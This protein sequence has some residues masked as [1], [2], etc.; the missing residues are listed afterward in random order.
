M[1]NGIL[2]DIIDGLRDEL[3][4]AQ[5]GITDLNDVVK[6]LQAEAIE[7]IKDNK[8]L[9][10]EIRQLKADITHDAKVCYDVDDEHIKIVDELQTENEKLRGKYALMK[11]LTKY[12]KEYKAEADEYFHH[13]PKAKSVSFYMLD[14]CEVDEVEAS[15][16]EPI[17][18]IHNDNI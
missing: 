10:A 15:Y 14:D 13:N 1:E 8:E 3:N 12:P 7:Q 17:A 9:K 16:H 5:D 2:W 6:D 18:I 4:I 11:S